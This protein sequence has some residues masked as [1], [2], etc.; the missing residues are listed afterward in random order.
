MHRDN[1]LKKYNK[2]MNKMKFEAA[3]AYESP[4]CDVVDIKTEG[5]L[6]YSFETPEEYDDPYD[7]N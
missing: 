7:W 4:K 6:C 2:T 1:H 3:M 5:V